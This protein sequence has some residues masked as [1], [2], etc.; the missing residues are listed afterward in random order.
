MSLDITPVEVPVVGDSKDAG[1]YAYNLF[2]VARIAVARRPKDAKKVKVGTEDR[3]GYTSPD[4]YASF[5]LAFSLSLTNSEAKRVAIVARFSETLKIR[6]RIVDAGIPVGKGYTYKELASTA[7][8]LRYGEK[9]SGFV[10]F[11]PNGTR[12]A[13]AEKNERFF[14]YVVNANGEVFPNLPESLK[15]KEVEGELIKVE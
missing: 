15:V 14:L 6:K 8:A 2:E 7:A 9:Y 10:A 11:R 1:I 13:V 3:G 4:R 12:F 5:R